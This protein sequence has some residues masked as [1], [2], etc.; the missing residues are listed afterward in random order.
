MYCF[1]QINRDL[2]LC[3]SCDSLL[4]CSSNLIGTYL[5]RLFRRS[6][7]MMFRICSVFAIALWNGFQTSMFS[8]CLIFLGKTAMLLSGKTKLVHRIQT[9]SCSLF[10]IITQKICFISYPDPSLV[11]VVVAGEVVCVHQDLLFQILTR[12]SILTNVYIRLLVHQ[13]NYWL[14]WY[15]CS[16]AY[17]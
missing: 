17:V 12:L 14:W 2:F 11:V 13:N 15:S 5:S 9:E 16:R 7:L 3:P 10:D 1:W 6:I 8:L 4:I